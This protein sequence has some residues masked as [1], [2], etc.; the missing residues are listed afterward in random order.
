MTGGGNVQKQNDGQPR[1]FH[2]LTELA[3]RKGWRRLAHTDRNGSYLSERTVFRDSVTGCVV[4]RMTCDPAVNVNDYYDIPVWNADGSMMAF[5][6][7]RGSGQR[8]RWL[9]DANGANLRPMPTPDGKPISTGYLSTRYRDRFYHL[10]EDADGARIVTDNPFTGE[11]QTLVTVAREP[12]GPPGLFAFMPPHP[13]EEWFLCGV[14]MMTPRPEGSDTPSA[15]LVI[16]LDGRVQEAR[17]ER[18][19]HRLRF[20]KAPDRRLFFNFDDPRTQWTILPDGTERSSI[21]DT[22]SHPDWSPDGTELTYYTRGAV[23]G[24]RHDG[25]GKRLVIDLQSGGHGGPFTDGEWFASDT[26]PNHGNY[27][28]SIICFRT[29]GS[30]IC[31]TLF[32]HL[33]SFY[34]HHHGAW[35]PDSHSTHPHP[36]SSPDGTKVVFGSDFLGQYADMYVVVNRCPD[37]PRELRSIPEDA[38]VSL[39]WAEPRRCRETR[40]YHV[41]RS[42]ESGI[43]YQRVTQEPVTTTEWRG[44]PSAAPGYYVVTAVE[45][46]GLESRP[47]NEV[48][49]QGR[50]QGAVRLAIEAEGGDSALPM[51]ELVLKP[52]LPKDADYRLWARVKGDGSLSVDCDGAAWGLLAYAGDDWHWQKTDGLRTLAAGE[53]TLRLQPATGRECIDRVLLTDD[54]D[55][56]PEGTLA[57]DTT[58]PDTPQGVE[59][60][61]LS[62]NTLK[63]T[64]T[65]V[66]APDLDHYNVYCGRDA[67]FVCDQSTLIGSPSEPEFVDWGLELNTTHRYHVTA[68]DRAGNESQPSLVVD[69][70]TPPFEPVLIELTA[71]TAALSQTQIVSADGLEAG[72]L[73]PMGGEGSAAW[74]FEIPHDGEY[75]IWGKSLHEKPEDETLGRT[76]KRF[77][78]KC[79]LTIDDEAPIAWEGWGYWGD[80][81]WSPA[82]RMVTGSPELFR[83]KAGKHTLRLRMDAGPSLIAGIVITD[84][85]SWYP[86]EG[87]TGRQYS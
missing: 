65:D 22:G 45:W 68:V 5:L 14:R 35:H 47:S 8:T 60:T 59:V 61:P 16:G 51:R 34:S 24:I 69:G 1:E 41:Y 43:N 26:P 2:G 62:A 76:G 53:H 75:A 86:V 15:A 6:S 73:Q 12:G 63:I 38:A 13:S 66:A 17:F 20:T 10:V 50:W 33:S 58:P 48:F 55:F 32:K 27:P 46:S 30:E 57:L 31:H 71:P 44:K 81:H 67:D 82:G 40:G 72:A 23:W 83:L 84:D 54:L 39:R 78:T 42:D 29:D 77:I 56:V 37:P 49:E 80:W 64:W 19:W 85:P 79:E 36:N 18:R 11:R 87:M 3:T 74:E 4:W 21:P 9:M 28:G 70:A 7:R 25:T 52:R